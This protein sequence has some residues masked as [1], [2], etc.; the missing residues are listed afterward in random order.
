VTGAESS[1]DAVQLVVEVRARP[2]RQTALRSALDRLTE[3]THR[4]DTGVLRFEVGVDAADDT[5]YVGYEVWAS[6]GELD[7]HATQPHT[8]Q[9]LDDARGLVVDPDAPLQVTRWRPLDHPLAADYPTTVAPPAPP[10]TGFAHQTATL[11]DTT[12]HYVIGGSGD[13]VVLLHGFPNTWY[14][15]REVMPALAERHTVLAVDLRG[16]GDSRP[17][18]RPNDVPTSAEDL[19][20]LVGQLGLGPVAV[21]GQDWGGSTGYAWAAGHP[22]EVRRLAVLEALP[23]GPW[24]PAGAGRQ[25]AWFAA[26]HQIPDLPERLVAGREPEYLDWF[27]TAFSATPGVPT[28]D[29]VAEYLRCYRQPHSMSSGFARYRG[30]AQEITHNTGRAPVAIP[31][32]AMGGDRV[33]GA[34]VAENLSSAA[35]DVRGEV[36]EDC[37]HYL[38][39]ERP[40]EV[41]TSLLDFFGEQD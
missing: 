14:A 32:L 17:G 28:A 8:R 27:Y 21:A 16:L 7:R 6:Q 12:L 18:Q 26:F 1:P 30:V 36:L 20:R 2:G 15:W 5:R 33:F 31:V 40:T 29:A 11:E 37:G 13:P 35:A 10:P 39:E 4:V 23:A 19:H 34:T 41:T 24:T 22:D 3:A 25:G 9:F 38:T